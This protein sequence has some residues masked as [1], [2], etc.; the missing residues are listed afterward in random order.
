MAAINADDLPARL[1]K[2]VSRQGIQKTG[3]KP[4]GL[5]LEGE[6]WKWRMLKGEWAAEQPPDRMEYLG[7]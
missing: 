7:I 3:A 1:I 6:N 2:C 4:A 5:L